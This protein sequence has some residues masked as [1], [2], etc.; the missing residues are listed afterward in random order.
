MLTFA[1]FMFATSV[2]LPNMRFKGYSIP[3]LGSF[4]LAS[5]IAFLLYAAW[6]F[7]KKETT[8][9]PLNLNQSTA[10]VTDG[11]FRITRNPMYLGMMLLLVGC[12]IKTAHVLN[13][14]WVWGFIIYM[15]HL[16][17]KPEE[18]AM[19][20]L[21]GDEYRAYKKRVRRWI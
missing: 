5:G 3:H 6:S 7:H 14:I 13:I 9:N 2:F 1:A 4:V 18:V 16:Q 17:I 10:L 8:V 11:P 19:E 20:R 12:A 15:T 21:F